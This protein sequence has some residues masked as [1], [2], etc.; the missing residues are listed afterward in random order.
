M[1]LGFGHLIGAWIPA[2]IFEKVKKTELS[3]TFW[4]LLLFGSIL[5]D[6][7]FLIEWLNIFPNV[8]RTFTHSL[9]FIGFCF[10]VLFLILK[11]LKPHLP[12]KWAPK[13]STKKLALALSFGVASH[14]IYDSIFYPGVNLLWPF[15]WWFA[16]GSFYFAT[17]P[18]YERI[19]GT[20]QTLGKINLF[21]LDMGMGAAW[22]FYFLI[23][24]RLKP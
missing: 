1:S 18:L 20:I 15:D 14:I 11:F 8:H 13:D 19:G 7:D 5:P 22:F 23:S 16:Q 17:Q 4:G 3:I 21:I 24:G 6:A 2:K 12:K 10:C 9:F